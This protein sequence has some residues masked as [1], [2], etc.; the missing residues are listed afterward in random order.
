MSAMVDAA[1]SPE[2]VSTITVVSPART[3]PR[4]M[5]RGIAAATIELVGSAYRPLA[6]SERTAREISSSGTVWKSPPELATAAR[7]SRSRTGRAIVAPSARVGFQSPAA[8]ADRP[9]AK[10]AAR[11]LQ[12]SGWATRIRGIARIAP[13]AASS[14]NPR[15]HPST[16]LPDPAGTTTQSGAAKPRSSQI[17]YARSFV[18]CRKN[19][20][21]LWLA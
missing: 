4:A 15:K 21:Q 13:D 8:E 9:A 17:S 19:G 5:R 3:S 7:T 11:G 18:P 6:A 10:A 2:P 20:C 14:V 12:F 1:F 16:R